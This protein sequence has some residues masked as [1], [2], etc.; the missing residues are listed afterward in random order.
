MT[1]IVIAGTGAVYEGRPGDSLLQV[2]QGEGH[3]IATTCGGVATC[4]LCRVTVKR[5]KENLSP[6]GE[7]EVTHLGSIAKVVG[8]RLACQAKCTG[9]GEVEVDVPALTDVAARKAE[10]AQRFRQQRAAPQRNGR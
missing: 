8:L 2:L 9:D 1:R 5:G 4:S 10:K 7:N 3:P 6:I